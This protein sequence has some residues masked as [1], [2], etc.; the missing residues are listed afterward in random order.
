MLP[1]RS[2]AG[3]QTLRLWQSINCIGVKN[4]Y[5][6][7]V[8]LVANAATKNI[9]CDNGLKNNVEFSRSVAIGWMGLVSFVLE[10][11]CI[12]NVNIAIC[13]LITKSKNGC[14]GMGKNLSIVARIVNGKMSFMRMAALMT[15]TKTN[16]EISRLSAGLIL[17]CVFYNLR[18][19]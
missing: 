16:A 9:S 1:S 7:A 6:N 19:L 13:I 3:G 5:G 12:K 15:M 10:L 8:S 11:L 2:A 4:C 14:D 18:R 17:L